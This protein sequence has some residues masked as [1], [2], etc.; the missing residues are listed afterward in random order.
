MKKAFTLIELL[1]VIAI[2]AI[3]A[4]ILFPVFAQAKLAAK[5]TAGLAAAKQIG[6]GV[7]IYLGDYD[8]NLPPYRH[9]SSS[10]PIVNPYYLSLQ[11]GDPKKATLET[12]G[13]TTIRGYF[14]NQ[15]LHP[16]IKSDDLWKNTQNPEAWVNFQDKGSFD[17]NFHSYGGQ[18]SYGVS[19]YLVGSNRA[20]PVS[21]IA[22]VSNT[23][24]L[25][26]ATYYNVLPAQ[27]TA[28]ACK[29]NGFNPS[30]SYLHYWKHLGNNK[31]NFNALGSPDPND[32]SN[33]D[34]IAKVESRY[35]GVL[36]I[37]RA[38]SSAK[39]QNAKSVINDLRNKGEQS[40]WNP[41]KTP[42]E[43]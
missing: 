21:M 11:N 35:S 43:L 10:G 6:T 27:P 15:M 16:Y 19:N 25:V 42:C 29:L 5:K 9:G 17:P 26:D 3:L 30:G 38:D 31:L 18:N 36:N 2:I 23:L 8:D 1:V 33:V 14:F 41:G 22:E 37:V 20:T 24:Y 28:G 40:M 4:A 39:A 13:Q 7:Q 32:P 34:E 12:S